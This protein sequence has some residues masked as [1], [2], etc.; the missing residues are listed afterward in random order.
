M[1]VVVPRT[2]M[3]FALLVAVQA[4]HSVEEYI[5]RLWESFPPAAFVSSIVP[6]NHEL[7]FVLVNF[8]LLAFGVWCVI[9]SAVPLIWFWV[10]IEII[11]GIGHPLWSFVQGGYTPGV[12]TAPI[13]LV[14]AWNLARQL[15]MKT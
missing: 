4:M 13:L 12:I 3:S 10:V 11:N 15:R 7:G 5:G 1:T 6:S 9:R 14:L 8:A 2:R